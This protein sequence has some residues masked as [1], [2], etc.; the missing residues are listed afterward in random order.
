MHENTAGSIGGSLMLFLAGAAIGGL[1][2]A[3]NTPK[4][5][6]ELREDLKALGNRARRKAAG[7][8]EDAEGAWERLKDT[9]G[10]EGEA[11]KRN[12]REATRT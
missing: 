11:L 5:G 12:L 7:L 2:V 6:P 9:A 10:E 4:T 3:L 8:A 1:V